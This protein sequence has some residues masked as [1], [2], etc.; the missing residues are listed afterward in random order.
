MAIKTTPT[1]A[2]APATRSKPIACLRLSNQHADA[3]AVTMNARYA[4]H[5]V[6]TCT[7]IIRTASPWSTSFG[8]T[9][10]PPIT[11]QAIDTIAN[12]P[13]NRVVGVATLALNV[14]AFIDGY[15]SIPL[16]AI[17]MTKFHRAQMRQQRQRALQPMASHPTPL[18]LHC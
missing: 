16:S 1:S 7:Y 11:T 6:G 8:V 14:C 3:K 4:T 15:S 10:N 2:D 13:I 9:I 5:A 18:L 17:R 12:A